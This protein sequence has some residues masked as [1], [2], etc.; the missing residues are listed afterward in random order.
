MHAATVTADM[1]KKFALF[2]LHLTMLA[3]VCAIAAYWAVRIMTPAPASAPPLQPS[4]APR[5]ADPV[6]AARMF[7]LVQT[8][9]AQLAINVQPIG[10]FAAGEDSAA[11][12]AVDGQPPRVFLLNQQVGGSAKLVAV[13]KDAVTIEQGGVRRDFELPVPEALSVGGSPPPPA[14][15]R[16]GNTLTAPTVAGAAPAG[17]SAS[18]PLPVPPRPAAMPP[19][20][21]V[22][23]QPM[24]MPSPPAQ[25]EQSEPPQGQPHAIPPP[26]A[27][28][29]EN[30][31]RRAVPGRPSSQ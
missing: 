2:L 27:A 6:L 4:A 22:Q 26:D 28:Q 1:P 21:P 7:G 5:E 17:G 10:V 12:L 15:T 19:S 14:Y 24:P 16:E 13:R 11:V 25:P 3:I 20:V 23:P 8:A 9:A 18:R 30:A 29:R 31:I